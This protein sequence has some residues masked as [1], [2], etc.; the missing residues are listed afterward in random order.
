MILM[1]L[2]MMSWVLKFKT[3]KE[4]MSFSLFKNQ[5]KADCASPAVWGWCHSRSLCP[6]NGNICSLN[7][8]TLTKLEGNEKESSISMCLEQ[9][10]D[11][12]FFLIN[13]KKLNELSVSC[14][15]VVLR[16]LLISTLCFWIHPSNSALI[17]K[18]GTICLFD[19]PL[20]GHLL[21]ARITRNLRATFT[22]RLCSAIY[23]VQLW[24]LFVEFLT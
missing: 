13:W 24:P 15:K 21:P 12:V 4:R 11:E 23:R 5:P 1:I 6:R 19:P 16:L 2:I 17:A 10:P 20:T 7:N 9:R 18:L 3:K 22:P 8:W 14:L